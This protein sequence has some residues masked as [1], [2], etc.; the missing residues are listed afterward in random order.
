[1]YTGHPTRFYEKNRAAIANFEFDRKDYTE[2]RAASK[3][4]CSYEIK[5]L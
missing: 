4:L 3:V 2:H 1:M 5:M